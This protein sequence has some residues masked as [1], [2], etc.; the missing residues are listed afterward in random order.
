MITVL[1]VLISLINF[2]PVRA[3][4]EFGVFHSFSSKLQNTEIAKEFY[5]AVLKIALVRPLS[6]SDDAELEDLGGRTN[7]GRTGARPR[8]S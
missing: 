4:G 5:F 6:I 2:S 1:W 7:S 3:Y 8:G